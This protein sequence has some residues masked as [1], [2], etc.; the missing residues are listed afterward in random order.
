MSVRMEYF[1]LSPT[2]RPMA[3][4]AQEDL[5]GTPASIRASEP[6]QAVAIG[7]PAG[8]QDV[9]AENI[10]AQAFKGALGKRAL[11]VH[12]LLRLL[13]NG[14]EDFLLQ[15]IDQVIAFLLWM[16]LGIERIVQPFAVFLLQ[17]LVDA[18]VEG[19]RL[20]GHFLGLELA[21]KLLN[22]RDD[23]FVLL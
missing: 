5:M 13:G 22:S 7:T 16:L 11:L 17:I 10:F 20:D 1:P 21:V 6:P 18:F 15:G 8:I 12:L 14:G 23:F 19:Q 4:P 3:M 9:V 2:T